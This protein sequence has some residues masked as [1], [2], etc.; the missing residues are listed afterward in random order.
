MPP[1]H[2][3]RRARRGNLA[4]P[5]PR[6]PAD[7]GAPR[8]V[9]RARAMGV[10]P[11]APPSPA[12]PRPAGS[13]RAGDRRGSGADGGGRSQLKVALGASGVAEPVRA[14]VAKSDDLSSIPGTD[15]V[16]CPLTSRR[17]HTLLSK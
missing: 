13:G 6:E 17:T 5:E 1:R 10:P 7:N 3:A 4:F 8:R 12:G 15:V 2:A 14:L 11:G 9:R 16:E